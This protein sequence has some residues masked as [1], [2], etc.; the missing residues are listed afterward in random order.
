MV[1]VGIGETAVMTPEHYEVGLSPAG[2]PLP[3]FACNSR[4]LGESK[5]LRSLAVLDPTPDPGRGINN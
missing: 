3:H 1:V 2:W 4:L 5:A